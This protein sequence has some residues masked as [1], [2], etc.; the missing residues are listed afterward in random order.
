[1]SLFRVVD[2][3]FKRWF[4]VV[5][6]TATNLAGDLLNGCLREGEHESI[7][8]ANTLVDLGVFGQRLQ[9][10]GGEVIQTGIP[11]FGTE[12]CLCLSDFLLRKDGLGLDLLKQLATA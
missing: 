12:F 11:P 1:M 3:A 4:K 6:G 8:L 9:L 7:H 5:M 10:I 2:S